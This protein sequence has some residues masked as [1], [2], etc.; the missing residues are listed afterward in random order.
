MEECG[1]VEQCEQIAELVTKTPG[2]LCIPVLKSKL[3]NAGRANKVLRRKMAQFKRTLSRTRPS[4]ELVEV[5]EPIELPSCE[6]PSE[7]T[8]QS[9]L[10][11]ELLRELSQLLLVSP[12]Q[13]RY[14]DT[15]CKFA[16]LVETTSGL[17]YRIVGYGLP[18]ES[19]PRQRRLRSILK[20]R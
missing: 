16:F 18:F 17:G 19:F 2:A 8:G 4:E 14:S 20:L 15:I 12:K 10:K 5:E 1:Q 13:R 11:A 6:S 9:G 7:H 3:A